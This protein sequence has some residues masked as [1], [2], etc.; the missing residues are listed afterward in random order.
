MAPVTTEP[1][2]LSGAFRAWPRVRRTPDAYA[3][4]LPEEVAIGAM[5]AQTTAKVDPPSR[6]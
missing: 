1:L 4:G 5:H 6:A 2:R 3:H